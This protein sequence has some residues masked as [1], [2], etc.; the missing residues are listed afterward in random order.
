MH[1]AA[2]SLVC[3]QAKM[4]NSDNSAPLIDLRALL[5]FI[6]LAEHGSIS[7][8]ATALGLSQP[9][10]SENVARLER[11]LQVKLALR[12][13]RGATLTE[14]G[15]MLATEGK[16]LIGKA[17]ALAEAVREFGADPSGRVTVGLPPS[18][19]VLLSVPLAET[20]R[21]ELP[22]IRLHVAEASSGHILGWL[23]SEDY[24]LGCVFEPANSAVFESIPIF[25]E[26]LY[27]AAAHD[28]LPSGL[29]A[30]PDRRVSPELLAQLPL[31]LPSHPH[32]F[33]RIVERYAR[34]HGVSLDVVTEIDSLPQIVEMV[35]RASAYSLLPQSA[36]TG[37][38]PTGQL[39][40][41]PLQPPCGRTAY[42][43]KKRAKLASNAT[44]AVQRVIVQ[45]IGELTRRH[46][47]SAVAET[48][49]RG[50]SDDIAANAS[51]APVP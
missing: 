26:E 30:S 28:D 5:N 49:S 9:S 15:R 23:G 50:A 29:D 6:M 42:L 7:A 32:G 21:A 46:G 51:R 45:I 1:G 10:V 8:A 14:A 36:L 43:V 3:R 34:T 25:T 41:L 4:H 47:L 35:S 40:L 2:A 27:F 31:V 17:N 18:L 12:G 39:A 37:T 24:D 48:P 22:N 16:E 19:N 44:M 13:P 11:K 33:R 38:R 20:V